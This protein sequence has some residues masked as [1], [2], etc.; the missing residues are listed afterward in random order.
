MT[1]SAV[2]V[3]SSKKVEIDMSCLN[4]NHLEFDVIPHAGRYAVTDHLAD[5]TAIWY[6]G[7]PTREEAERFVMALPAWE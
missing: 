4:A 2:K 6:V 7:F 1:P 5:G 3:I